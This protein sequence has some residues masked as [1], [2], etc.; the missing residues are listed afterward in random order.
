M[1]DFKVLWYLKIVCNILN[2]IKND[3]WRVHHKFLY[4]QLP[5]MQLFTSLNLQAKEDSSAFWRNK[6]VKYLGDTNKFLN[7]F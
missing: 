2:D 3:F 6:R 7:H 1:L 4:K 5:N